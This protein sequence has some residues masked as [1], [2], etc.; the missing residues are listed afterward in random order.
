MVCKLELDK[1][2]FLENALIIASSTTAPINDTSKLHRLKPVTPIPPSILNINPPKK[3]P[4]VPTIMLLPIPIF[5]LFPVK[6][7]ASHP[8]IPPIMIQLNI[9]IISSFLYNDWSNSSQFYFPLLSCLSIS[10]FTFSE[11][12]SFRSSPNSLTASLISPCFFWSFPSS[13]SCSEPIIFPVLSLMV[14]ATLSNSQEL[15]VMRSF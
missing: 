1:I 10:S 6:I 3:P 2:Y 15:E 8:A 5:L 9:P 12:F 14:P 4:R 13:S 11:A 7:L